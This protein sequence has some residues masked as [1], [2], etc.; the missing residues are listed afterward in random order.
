MKIL[1]ISAFYHDSAASLINDGEIIAAAQEERFT[2]IKQDSS[3]PTRSIKYCLDEAMINLD[4]LDYII[5]YEKPFL[6]FER[7]IENYMA[8][9]PFGLKVFIK[10]LPL[11]IKSKF[12]QKKIII[13]K[14]GEIKSDIDFETKLLFAEHHESHAASAFYPSPFTEAAIVTIDGVGEYTTTSIGIGKNNHIEIIKEIYF[15]HSVGLLYSSF[16]QFL[17]F[18][19]NSAEYKVMGLAPY[20]KPIYKDLILDKLI[21]LKE[22]GSFRIN[23]KYFGYINS[24]EMINLK[25]FEKLFKIKKRYEDQEITSDHI[26]I[27]SSIQLVTNIIVTKLVKHAKKLT[28][29]NNLVMAGGVALNCVTNGVLNQSNIFKNIWI[30]PASGDAGGSLGSALLLYYKYK[31]N[32]RYVNNMS[33]SMQGSYFGPSFKNDEIKLILDRKNIK[34]KYF[35]NKDIIKYTAKEILNQ[36]IIG[37]FSGRMEF[38]PRSLGNRSILCDPRSETMQSELNLKIKFRE[39]FRPFAPAILKEE[40]NNWFESSVLDPYMLFVTK[41]KKDK[42]YKYNTDIKGFELLK[43]KRSQ[44]SAITHVDNS[45]RYQIVYSKLNEKFYKLIKEFYNLSNCPILVNTSFNVRG[46]PIVCDPMDAIN[47]FFGTNLDFLVLENY[48]ISKKDNINLLNLDYI[49]KFNKD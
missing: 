9:T 17:G 37:W 35:S 14:L 31:R 18:K 43:I 47:C 10:T 39:G 21:D 29:Q 1:G 45:S 27:A 6:K 42:L 8:A 48:F 41:L 32:K 24:F 26:N 7:L 23:K 46:E 15:P 19:V 34:Y 16:T 33:D 25:E 49:N 4:D 11:W 5:F 3:F 38:G 2:R 12:F 20:G 22:D 28:S 30:Q 40:F 13:K 44:A 36:K